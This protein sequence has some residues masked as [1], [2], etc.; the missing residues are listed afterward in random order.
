MS[1]VQSAEVPATRFEAGE[2]VQVKAVNFYRPTGIS[3]TRT[4]HDLGSDLELAAFALRGAWWMP[5]KAKF[6]AASFRLQ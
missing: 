6:S 3:V 2:C 1:G 5:K 4:A